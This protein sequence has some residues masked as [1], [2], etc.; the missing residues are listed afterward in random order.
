[1]SEYLAYSRFVLLHRENPAV[2]TIYFIIARWDIVSVSHIMN[3][4]MEI[5][6][7]NCVDCVENVNF[8]RSRAKLCRSPNKLYD[9]N[10]KKKANDRRRHGNGYF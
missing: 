5:A 7:R 6:E 2:N 10:G 9:M 1:M 3:I 4:R 8:Y